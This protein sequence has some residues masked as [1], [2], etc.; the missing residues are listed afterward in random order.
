MLLVS[1]KEEQGRVC[2][3]N[4]MAGQKPAGWRAII[5]DLLVC[6]DEFYCFT[7]LCLICVAA[8]MFFKNVKPR[9]EFF[10]GPLQS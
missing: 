9:E 6:L 2:P 3:A 8:S 10:G 7:L 4:P 5:C 1:A